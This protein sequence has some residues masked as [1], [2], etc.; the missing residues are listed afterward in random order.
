M[1]KF[2]HYLV[3]C[4]LNF[5]WIGATLFADSDGLKHIRVIWQ[6]NPAQESIISWTLEDY[7]EKSVVYY[8]DI[9]P[10]GNQ[11]NFRYHS[12]VTS[13]KKYSKGGEYSYHTVLKNL[14]PNT[15]Y[16][17]MIESGQ[18]KSSVFNFVSAPNDDQSFK[19]LFG[20]DSRSD[21]D[22]RQKMNAR[23]KELLQV[24]P[25]IYALVHGGD[26]VSNGGS[27]SQW[28]E[29]LEDHQAIVTRENR[30]LP[31]IAA[32]GN[33]EKDARLFNEIFFSPGQG[34][35]YYTTRIG[36]LAIV[37]LNTEISMN[38][39]QRQWLDRTLQELS[40]SASWIVANYHRAAWPAV[41]SPSGALQH[42]VPLFEKYLVD[43][44][45]ESDGHALKKTVPIRNKA[46]DDI[47]G[48]IY[49]GEGGLGV[50]QR[51]PSN[52]DKWYLNAQGA[53]AIS[54]HHVQLLT[55]HPNEMQYEV[56]LMN[57]QTHEKTVFYPRD[58]NL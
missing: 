57:G 16:Y 11:P 3:L 21:R 23:M 40:T 37:N 5:F 15:T 18:Q 12:L 48:I 19:L 34:N 33:H 13:V 51:K 25:S 20:G 2:K 38:G 32:R 22:D 31:I 52:K 54:A 7:D 10:D 29:W 6:E 41:K 45:F 1:K 30:L 9:A 26:Y 50:K 27:W 55:V 8:D 56:V 35:V 42:W 39:D 46:Q 43:L 49:V 4:S 36:H 58:R 53:Y 14:I 17:F 28:E 44:V 47:N 24:D